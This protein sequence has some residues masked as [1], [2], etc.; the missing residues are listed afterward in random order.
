MMNQT[1]ARLWDT[2]SLLLNPV[3]LVDWLLDQL[4]E[5]SPALAPVRADMRSSCSEFYDRP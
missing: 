1:I 5:L 4:D 2:G 3:R